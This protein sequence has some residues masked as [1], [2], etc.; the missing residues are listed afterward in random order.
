MNVIPVT[1]LDDF[2]PNPKLWVELAKTCSYSKASNNNWPGERSIS[3]AE[4]NPAAF[5]SLCGHF[6]S[7]FYP[8]EKEPHIS[9][10]VEARFQ[11]INSNG[12]GWIH[13]DKSLISGIVYLTEDIDSN[14]GTSIYTPKSLSSLLHTEKKQECIELNN[15]DYNAEFREINNAQFEESI[16]VSNR[17]NRLLAFD[18]TLPHRALSFD[19]NNKD[20]LTLVFFVEK[21]LSEETPV[22]R[23]K[24]IVYA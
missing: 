18:C 5:R 14:C 20:R 17:F 13:Y 23:S 22:F 3:L 6:F 2:L 8:L 11:K 4:L 24:R 9:W 15:L 10:K 21:L 7:I 16:R 19:N 1:V 12:E